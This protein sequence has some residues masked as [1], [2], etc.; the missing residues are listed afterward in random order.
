MKTIDTLNQE[1]IDIID[2]TYVN[3][4]LDT[5][6]PELSKE[7]GPITRSKGKLK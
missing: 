1:P 3:P 7:S 4:G 5:S 6:N 2:D